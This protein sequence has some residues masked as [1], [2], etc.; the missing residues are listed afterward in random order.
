MHH[1]WEKIKTEYVAGQDSYEQLARKYGML[2]SQLARKASRDKWP[3]QRRAYR[4]SVASATIRKKRHRDSEHLVELMDAAEHLIGH[5]QRTLEDDEQFRRNVES[6]FFKTED[7][8]WEFKKQE[9][10]TKK[11][12]TK[13][14]NN[15]AR[16]LNDTVRA[17]RD[18]YGLPTKAEKDKLELEKRKLKVLEDRQGGGVEAENTGVAFMPQPLPE[19]EDAV[20]VDQ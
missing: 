2:K 1:D 11:V 20:E 7:G 8:N 4:Q 16:A 12:D 10:L 6:G 9:Y 5:I 17:V 15:A 19:M 18:L 13:A 14:L 3:E